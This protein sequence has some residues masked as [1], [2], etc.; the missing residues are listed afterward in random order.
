M[1]L[2]YLPKMQMGARDVE[3]KIF[4]KKYRDAAD[5][6]ASVFQRPPLLQNV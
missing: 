1:S 2:V 6:I 3:S 5:E 4:I